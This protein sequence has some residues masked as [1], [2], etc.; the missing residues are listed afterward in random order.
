MD[1]PFKIEA[2]N[3]GP[4]QQGRLEVTPPDLGSSIET[5]VCLVPSGETV[6]VM[7]NIL[8]TPTVSSVI[9]LTQP[10]REAM[11]ARQIYRVEN[12]KLS[13]L[14]YVRDPVTL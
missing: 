4:T 14:V 13:S 11:V 1:N 7:S 6:M 5:R 3:E 9:E 2:H 10:D 8:W 12:G